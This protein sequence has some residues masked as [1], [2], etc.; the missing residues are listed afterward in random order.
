[1]APDMANSVHPRPSLFCVAAL[2]VTLLNIRRRDPGSLVVADLSFRTS[3]VLGLSDSR[4]R[5]GAVS[6]STNRQALG[7]GRA[8]QSAKN[9]RRLG[10]GR[11]LGQLRD[12]VQLG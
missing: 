5:L 8:S 6:R 12:G 3:S 7:S 9:V 11:G 1:M 2:L 4:W 10:G